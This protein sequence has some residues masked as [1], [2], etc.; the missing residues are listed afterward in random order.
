MRKYV[1]VALFLTS[2][3]VFTTP[4]DT[5]PPLNLKDPE[6]VVMRDVEFVVIH[7]ENAEKAFSDLEKSGEEPVLFALPGEDYKNLAANT[8]RLKAYIKTQ[9]KIIRLYREYYEGVK[10]GKEKE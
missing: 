10:N 7:K 5:K 6:P 2:C 8:Q 3:S 1:L 4:I 9:Q